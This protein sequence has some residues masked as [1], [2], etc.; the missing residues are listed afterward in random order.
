MPYLECLA[1]LK[2]Y[3]LLYR[4]SRGDLIEFYKHTHGYYTT[5]ADYIHFDNQNRHGHHLKVKK[6][7]TKYKTKEL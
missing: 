2:L 5:D 3:S 6:K 7:H 4:R 1:A